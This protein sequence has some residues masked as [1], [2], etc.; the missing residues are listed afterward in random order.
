MLP[1]K[2]GYIQKPGTK[3]GT[4]AGYKS[5]TSAAYKRYG[6]IKFFV[7]SHTGWDRPAAL[8]WPVTLKWL[9][10]NFAHAATF[11]YLTTTKI[12]QLLRPEI[13]VHTCHHW[14]KRNICV[15]CK[16]DYYALQAKS[17]VLKRGKVHL[18]HFSRQSNEHVWT[19][20]V[21]MLS[22]QSVRTS[23]QCYPGLGHLGLGFLGY[24]VC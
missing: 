23:T 21:C 10:L 3:A 16:K 18:K 2:A 1:A 12:K 24:H 6:I 4:K 9:C 8:K 11:Y 20:H 22:V 15:Q 5:G 17:S 7:I 19:M 14:K 13:E